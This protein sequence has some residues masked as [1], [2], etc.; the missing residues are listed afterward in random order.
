M[1]RPLLLV[2]LVT[3]GWAAGAESPLFDAHLHY[4]GRER[5]GLTPREALDA[6]AASGVAR[7]LVTGSPPHHALALHRLDPARVVPLLGVY[8]EPRD[9]QHWY[10]DTTLPARVASALDAGPWR[11]IGELHLFAPQRHSPVFLALVDLAAARGLPLLLH[12]DPTVID[13]VFER[14]PT[15][16]VLWAHAGAYPC[17]PLLRDYLERYPRLYLDLSMRDGRVAPGGALDPA[18]E[19]LLL[20]YPKR[21]MVGVD[22]FSAGR[23][24]DLGT[25]VA[26]TRQWLRQLPPEVAERIAWGNGAGLFAG[27]TAAAP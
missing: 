23:W 16:T 8:Q 4:D 5:S 17:P 15:A 26:V 10:R 7:A 21:V 1:L 20:E 3:V 11:G 22:T 14:A 2:V 19:L 13:T 18:W 9:K 25:V 27:P 12:T 6:L 24:R